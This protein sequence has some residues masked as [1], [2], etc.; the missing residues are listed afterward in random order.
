MRLAIVLPIITCPKD[1]LKPEFT[2]PFTAQPRTI[3]FSAR[4]LIEG[5]GTD[6][7]VAF[8]GLALFNHPLAPS[9]RGGRG[10]SKGMTRP[11]SRP[12]GLRPAPQSPGLRTPG[13]RA[14]KQ[15][16]HDISKLALGT[17]SSFSAVRI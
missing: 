3:W 17:S 4:F 15:G 12:A 7:T 14:D 13:R 10:A 16:G 8:R 6:S 11:P 5:V 1:W 2:F 9:P